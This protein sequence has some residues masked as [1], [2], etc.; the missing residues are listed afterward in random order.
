MTV[1]AQGVQNQHGQLILEWSEPK[2]Q[3]YTISGTNVTGGEL[4]VEK[5]GDNIIPSGDDQYTTYQWQSSSDGTNWT[6]ITWA[7]SK[8]IPNDSYA[9]KQIKA[10]VTYN[11][12]SLVD[13][14]FQVETAA[15]TMNLFDA[16]QYTWSVSGTVDFEQ[17]Q[18]QD[19]CW[20]ALAGFIALL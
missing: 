15:V 16:S 6:N 5:D 1:H 12:K 17:T 2:K 3:Q 9:D 13:Q 18:C 4:S 14:V 20:S 11:M 7:S 8:F 10:L 19:K